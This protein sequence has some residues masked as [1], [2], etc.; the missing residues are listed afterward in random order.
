MIVKNLTMAFDLILWKWNLTESYKRGMW[1]PLWAF[2]C[3]WKVTWT[4]DAIQITMELQSNSKAEI[5][6]AQ[7]IPS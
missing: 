6:K 1:Y 7:I 2:V 4:R 3:G 5:Q